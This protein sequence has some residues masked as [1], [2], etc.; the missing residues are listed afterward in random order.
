MIKSGTFQNRYPWVV[1]LMIM[2]S[3]SKGYLFS[4][5]RR[6]A[7]TLHESLTIRYTLLGLE[8]LRVLHDI[9]FAMHIGIAVVDFRFRIEKWIFL[10]CTVVVF[11]KWRHACANASQLLV[12]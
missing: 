4:A 8:A 12:F 3:R 6:C 9:T 5:W 11:S 1:T 2:Y 10:A 7:R